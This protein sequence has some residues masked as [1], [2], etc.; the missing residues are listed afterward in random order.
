M[1]VKKRAID[2]ETLRAWA[3]AHDTISLRAIAR[4]APTLVRVR[5]EHLPWAALAV[6]RLAQARS[7]PRAPELLRAALRMSTELA[8]RIAL[9]LVP[10]AHDAGE[11]TRL[12]TRAETS[13]D[14]NVVTEATLHRARIAQR[15]G[16]LG[17]A[18]ALLERVRDAPVTPRIRAGIDVVLGIQLLAE[19]RRTTA[20]ERLMRAFRWAA[21]NGADFEAS[22]VAGML[23]NAFHDLGELVAATRWYEGAIRH[24]RTAGSDLTVGIFSLYAGWVLHERGR[25]VQAR[26]RY[27]QAQRLLAT[28]EVRRFRLHA[29]ALLVLAKRG[30]AIDRRVML[31]KVATELVT[32]GDRARAN[33]IEALGVVLDAEELAH[34]TSPALLVLRAARTL[35]RP[36][37][38]DDE[39]IAHRMAR[40]AIARSLPKRRADLVI[41]TDGAWFRAGARTA[42]LVKHPTQARLL[43]AL[44]LASLEERRLGTEELIAIGWPGERMRVDA[45]THRLHVALSTLRS[46]GLGA[47]LVR[48]AQGYAIVAPSIAV[49]AHD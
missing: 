3:D 9:A 21:G 37:A 1:R 15:A 45:A 33:A 18:R 10:H 16:A 48:D 38:S 7:V 23:G 5:G 26:T 24:A 19:G 13:S 8:P 49:A 41:A 6:A 36:A 44:V 29:N 42:S 43:V 12:L 46:R 31:A 28:P 4:A 32:I 17:E 27:R 11:A 2:H 34:A 40:R 25:V 35:E 47:R 22:E 14:A 20:H 30:P 39:R